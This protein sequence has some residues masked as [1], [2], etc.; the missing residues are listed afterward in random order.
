LT[1]LKQNGILGCNYKCHFRTK[2]LNYEDKH[3]DI[4]RIDVCEYF[5]ICQNE[6]LTRIISVPSY[7]NIVVHEIRSR[8]IS[9]HW[10]IPEITFIRSF[11]ILRNQSQV[12]NVNKTRNT[13]TYINVLPNQV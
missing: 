1:T 10:T 2:K 3:S 9:I 4:Y 11:D 13:Y 5:I 7:P 12:A 6:S 8:W